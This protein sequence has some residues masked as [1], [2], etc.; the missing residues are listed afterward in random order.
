MKK[1]STKPLNKDVGG[2]ELSEHFSASPHSQSDLKVRIL[3]N[4]SKVGKYRLMDYGRFVH[5]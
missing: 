2:T 1:I 5:V 3:D 4:N